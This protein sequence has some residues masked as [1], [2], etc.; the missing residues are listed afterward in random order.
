MDFK[1]V[2]NNA[3]EDDP[4]LDGQAA[5]LSGK[6]GTQ[7]ADLRVRDQEI[8]FFPNSGHHGNRGQRPMLRD[9]V[10]NLMEIGLG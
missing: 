1:G 5:K 4:A 7:L 10:Q 9:I 2:I 8:T 3:V 6:L